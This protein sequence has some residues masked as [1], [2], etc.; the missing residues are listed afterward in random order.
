[1]DGPYDAARGGQVWVGKAEVHQQRF[2]RARIPI[3]IYNTYIMC[4]EWYTKNAFAASRSKFSVVIKIRQS[5]LIGSLAEAVLR[6]LVAFF[7]C[8][9]NLK[10]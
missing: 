2:C 4:I 6:S 9:F 3:C 7:D 1:M 8:C 10:K 5:V